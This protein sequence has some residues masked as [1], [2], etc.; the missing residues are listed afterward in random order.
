MH[1]GH[2]GSLAH[3]EVVVRKRRK[4]IYILPNLFTLGGLFGGFYAIVMAMD[5]RFDQAAIGV[6]SAMIL[7]S[8]DG[9]IARMTNTQSAFGEQMDSLSDM[10]SFGAAPALIAYV[11]GLSTLGRWGW[12]AAFVYCACAALRLARFNVNTAVVDKRFFQGLPSPAA[13]ALVAGFIW[14]MNDADYTGTGALDLGFLSLQI[15]WLMFILTLYSGLT[16]VTNVP[17]YS[18]K[19]NHS[20]ERA[21]CCDC[22]D[23][24]RH[25]CHWPA[26]TDHGVCVFHRVWLV[27]LLGVCVAQS[28]GPTNQR[29]CH[30]SRRARRARPAQ[31]SCAIFAVMKRIS[32]ALLLSANGRIW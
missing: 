4:G 11:W 1:D 19:D 15:P 32:L 24:T 6:F 14:L 25:R 20:K 8:L 31:I 12:V 17:F 13:A 5:G 23:S 27:G 9:R 7:D 16:M 2:E 29:D 28:Q 26:S 30:I 10:V 22:F 21:L 18:F 3:P